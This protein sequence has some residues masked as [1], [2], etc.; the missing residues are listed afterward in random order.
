MSRSNIVLAPYP[1]MIG[2]IKFDSSEK[3]L[4]EYVKG[5]KYLKAKKLLKK[6]ILPDAVNSLGQTPLFIA[7]LLGLQKMVDLLLQYGSSPNHRCFDGSTPV[8]AAAFS[9]NTWIMSKLIDAGGDLRLHDDMSRRPLE[10]ACIAGKDLNA[11]MLEFMNCCSL[12]MHA[13][14]NGLHCES[15]KVEDSMSSPSLIQLLSPR[16]TD[17]FLPKVHKCAVLSGKRI[18]NFGYGELFIGDD[19]QVGFI[20]RVPLI[21]DKSIVQDDLKCTFSYAAG[22]YMTMTNLMWGCTEVTVKGLNTMTQKNGTLKLLDLLIVEQKNIS[23]LQHP[24]V[25]QLLAV[26]TSSTLEKTQLVFENIMFGSLYNILHERRS[27]FPV[28]HMETI[29]C[30][31]LQVLE[32]L[33]FLHWRGFIHCS[34]SSHAVQIVSAG[35][36]KI[37][38]F[39]YMTRRSDDRQ[40]SDAVYF[41]VPEELYPWS[42]PE[43]VLGKKATV[44]SDL[45][46]LCAVMQESLSDCLPW[47]GLN[48]MAIKDAMGSGKFLDTDP[49]LAQPYYSIVHTGLQNKPEKRTMDLR[50]IRYLLKNDTKGTSSSVTYT[51]GY[52]NME[53]ERGASAKDA[54]KKCPDMLEK[55][56]DSAY[57]ARISS[58]ESISAISATQS[59]TDAFS[60]VTEEASILHSDAQTS[61]NKGHDSDKDFHQ[62]ATISSS[63]TLSQT[64]SYVSSSSSEED[65]SYEDTWQTEFQTL[66]DRLTSI[67]AHNKTTLGN[68][69]Y[70]QNCLQNCKIISNNETKQ[71]SEKR[72][73]QELSHKCFPD[74]SMDEVDSMVPVINSKYTESCAMGPPFQQY[75]PP[76]NTLC[77]RPEF[78]K[79]QKDPKKTKTECFGGA[80]RKEVMKNVSCDTF[81]TYEGENSQNPSAIQ[82]C[83][84]TASKNLRS[85]TSDENCGN[86]IVRKRFST[87]R[88]PAQNFTISTDK[89]EITPVYSLHPSS[90]YPW[91]KKTGEHCSN[92]EKEKRTQGSSTLCTQENKEKKLEK[93]FRHFAGVRC[94]STVDENTYGTSMG[95]NPLLVR[96]KEVSGSSEASFYTAD[97]ELSEKNSQQETLSDESSKISGEYKDDCSLCLIDG[98][99]QNCRREAKQAKYGTGDR[100]FEKNMPRANTSPS[101]SPNFSSIIDVEGLSGI[102]SD[103]KTPTKNIIGTK[104]NETSA[105]HSTPIS[106]VCIVGSHEYSESLGLESKT[107]CECHSMDITLLLSESEKTSNCG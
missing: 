78:V 50:D 56:V 70:I 35:Y 44:K 4:H 85:C 100:P 86:E 21:E 54:Q 74:H 32:A 65:I 26:C 81:K 27:E 98:R 79:S 77:S 5:E 14:I 84:D 37:S 90:Q 24:R 52:L 95:W 96:F 93:L 102:S 97:S 106:P 43:I 89:Q 73:M 8:H 68:L 92:D 42:S 99:C 76:D 28:L 69:L 83:S 12:R 87:K 105:R 41:P 7:A 104:S 101:S 9:C 48:G 31:L 53:T 107:D 36:A 33:M 91:S 80:R 45:Y 29:T 1:V 3:H 16:S 19:N 94:P 39:E 88:D 30:L 66:E 20:S 60:E 23:N 6:G 103:L 67:H 72:H 40:C 61:E 17:R 57:K 22:P 11:Q 58:F 38:H 82:I 47:N 18:C 59:Y 2:T 25:L 63:A 71:P 64:S 49:R 34:F 13:L 51:S 46:S 55:V 10:W 15:M 75:V 62:D